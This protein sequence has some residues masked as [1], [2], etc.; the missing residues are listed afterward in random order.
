MKKTFVILAS[1][2]FFV[3]SI[4]N[5]GVIF[6]TVDAESSQ[7]I[8]ECAIADGKVALKNLPANWKFNKYNMSE[9]SCGVE[10]TDSPE[11][12]V[13]LSAQMEIVVHP[14]QNIGV[15]VREWAN[16]TGQH[17]IDAK[18]PVV[19]DVELSGKQG[20]KL[21]YMKTHKNFDETKSIEVKHIEYFFLTPDYALKLNIMF[22][23]PEA[24]VVEPELEAILAQIEIK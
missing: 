17:T 3:I 18:D 6:C 13:Y 11:N 5:S 24:A 19:T 21:T 20:C 22:N 9:R 23:E 15:T 12:V 2:A 16:S 14:R 8:T 7:D 4:S 10:K 1:I